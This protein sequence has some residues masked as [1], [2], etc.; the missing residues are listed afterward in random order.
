MSKDERLAFLHITSYKTE[1]GMEK[2]EVEIHGGR[3]P[4]RRRTLHRSLNKQH[5]ANKLVWVKDGEEARFSF[6]RV[7][8]PAIT[9]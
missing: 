1:N 7:S 8:M 5:L 9:E 4:Y 2:N 3:Q 6:Q